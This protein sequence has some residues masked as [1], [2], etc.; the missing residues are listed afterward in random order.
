ME[1]RECRDD[2]NENKWLT[3][4]ENVVWEQNVFVEVTQ[5][6]CLLL[7][8]S[9]I[10][11]CLPRV[12]SYPHNNITSVSLGAVQFQFP[13]DV[14]LNPGRDSTVDT[15]VKGQ[16]EKPTWDQYRCRLPK[17]C[18]EKNALRLCK[19]ADAL[20]GGE[21]AGKGF[22]EEGTVTPQIRERIRSRQSS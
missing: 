18:R 9:E 2:W 8:T 11:S 12:H 1:K 6:F 5:G 7:V 19:C 16:G 22:L 21:M 14:I 10:P 13:V 15:V 4:V 17:T 20:A 3:Y